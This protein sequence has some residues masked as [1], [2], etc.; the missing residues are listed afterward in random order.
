ML[1]VASAV[2][3]VP[4]LNTKASR[5][6]QSGRWKY[7]VVDGMVEIDKGDGWY[8][9]C[10][11]ETVETWAALLASPTEEVPDDGASHPIPERRDA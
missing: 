9:H 2:A 1:A 5:V 3:C 10:D 6:V 4:D 11:A 8:A 7:R